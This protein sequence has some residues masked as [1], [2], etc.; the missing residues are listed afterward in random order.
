MKKRKTLV[1]LN[2]TKLESKVSASGEGVI[3]SHGQLRSK[4]L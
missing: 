4:F 2:L 1:G 3:E